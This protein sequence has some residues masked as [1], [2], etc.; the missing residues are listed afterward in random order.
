LPSFDVPTMSQH[1]F[2]Q[3]AHGNAAG[4]VIL[5]GEHFVVYTAPALA[6]PL[7]AWRTTVTIHPCPET[8][9][10]FHVSTHDVPLARV[11]PLVDAALEH[12]HIAPP[13]GWRL[14]IVT[15]IP[16]GQGLGASAS[17]AV[18]LAKATAEAAGLKPDD[19]EIHRCAHALEHI[20]HGSPSGIDDTTVM[21]ETPIY[22][23]RQHPLVPAHAQPPLHFA[24][25][26]SGQAGDTRAAIAAVRAFSHRAPR[27]FARL[28]AEATQLAA[29]GRHAFCAGDA[30]RL[31]ALMNRNH[32]LLQGIA[33]ST[34]DIDALVQEARNL[35]ASGAKLTGAG[36]GGSVVAVAAPEICER[37]VVHWRGLGVAKALALCV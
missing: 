2:C 4:K 32:T 14:E 35:G 7:T 27:D 21:G 11:R 3:P 5:L 23:Q 10:A 16:V 13:Q 9:T 26:A 20:V 1:L 8:P 24:V 30:A 17:I 6:L 12:W 31:G 15:A 37:I 29:E 19:A 28:L 34:P 36:L 33:V 18:A 22:F 25:A